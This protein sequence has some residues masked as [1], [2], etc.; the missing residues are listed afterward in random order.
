[1]EPWRKRGNLSL[2]GHGGA[3]RCKTGRACTRWWV[4]RSV[5]CLL[6]THSLA[7]DVSDALLRAFDLI[8][9]PERVLLL[10]S[11]SARAYALLPRHHDRPATQPTHRDRV[12]SPSFSRSSSPPAHFTR[13]P[14]PHAPLAYPAVRQS[15][16]ANP[17]SVAAASPGCPSSSRCSASAPL[18]RISRSPSMR[19][20][21]S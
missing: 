21:P 20:L 17:S 7:V 9:T 4:P 13:R 11:S 12:R 1:M 6:L 2:S 8:C 10:S 18:Y 5:A 3:Y 14:P 15:T 19:P 16:R